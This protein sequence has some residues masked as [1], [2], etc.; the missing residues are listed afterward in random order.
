MAQIESLIEATAIFNGVLFHI[1]I[2]RRVNCIHH[3]FPPYCFIDRIA[4]NEFFSPLN[5]NRIFSRIEL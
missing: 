2:V 4:A 1:Y 3:I 5:F